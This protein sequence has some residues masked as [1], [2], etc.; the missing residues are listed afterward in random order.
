MDPYD[1]TIKSII[2][3]SQPL[4]DGD[5]VFVSLEILSQANRCNT[6]TSHQSH[7]FVECVD[8]RPPCE[9][10][11]GETERQTRGLNGCGPLAVGDD[12]CIMETSG[13]ENGF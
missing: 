1:L 4:C 9:L 3:S 12:L 10:L 11:G 13:I 2:N 7:R 5:E 8:F 6:I